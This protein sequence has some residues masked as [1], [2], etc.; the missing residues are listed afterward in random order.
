MLRFFT[1]YVRPLLEYG[2]SVWSPVSSSHIAK[3]ESVQRFFSNEIPSCSFLPYSNRLSILNINSLYHCRL[4]TDL[5]TL[6]SLVSGHTTA[7]L[8]PNILHVP[9]SITRSHNL[10]LII[11]LLNHSSFSQNFVSCSAG[12]WNETTFFSV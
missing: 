11:P 10:K 5:T 6:H 2:S 9:H 7:S 3:I 12:D 4:I 8:F 1:T